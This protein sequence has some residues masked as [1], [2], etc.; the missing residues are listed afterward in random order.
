MHEEWSLGRLV[1]PSASVRIYPTAL[2]SIR[3]PRL[4]YCINLTTRTPNLP[5]GGHKF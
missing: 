5:Q 3:Y 4:V 1:N 2:H